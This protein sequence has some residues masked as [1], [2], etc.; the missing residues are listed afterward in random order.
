MVKGNLCV[1]ILL[2]LYLSWFAFIRVTL[3]IIPVYARFTCPIRRMRLAREHQVL[4][5]VALTGFIVLA[6]V[7]KNV[8]IFALFT[9]RMLE[10]TAAT[11][12]LADIRLEYS[13]DGL[14]CMQATTVTMRLLNRNAM[15]L[16]DV[17]Q[18]AAFVSAND[19]A[20]V[21]FFN[22]VA[23]GAVC[24]IIYISRRSVTRFLPAFFEL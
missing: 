7:R 15:K 1:T 3:G 2:K 10:V 24:P 18:L 5:V 23:A 13:L 16:T 19:P 6:Y 20:I 21:S 17:H 11:R 4:Y 8:D 9:D 12:A 22:S 14:R